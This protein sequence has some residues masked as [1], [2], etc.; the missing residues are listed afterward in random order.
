MFDNMRGWTDPA[1]NARLFANLSN[2]ETSGDGQAYPTATGFGSAGLA[3]STSYIYIAIRRGPMKVPTVGTSV[4]SPIADSGSIGATVTNGFPIDMQ[5]NR[6]YANN[7]NSIVVDRLRGISTDSTASVASLQINTTAAES[8]GTNYSLFWGNTSFQ[9]PNGYGD[10]PVIYW[11]FRRAPSFFDEVCYT[12]NQTVRAISHNLGIAPELFLLFQ[13]SPAADVYARLANPALL[14]S[15]KWLYVNQT[16]AVQTSTNIWNNTAPTA[17][18]FTVGNST[19]SNITGTTYVAYLFATCAGVSK[20]GSYTGNGTTQTI[21]C[22][23]GAGGARFVL[24]KR[25][26][27][28]GDWYVYDTA[29]GMTVL[30]DPYL[31]LNNVAAQVATLGSVTTVSTGFALDSAILAA[32]NVNAGTYIFL[33]IA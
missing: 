15:N 12:G 23:F 3:A 19:A 24:I 8:V 2:A 9:V 11:S 26:D 20:V 21:N 6:D 30:T 31:R 32:I 5:I 18:T 10:V 25:T 17:S 27:A 4:F 14:G 28:V 33:A 7:G 13:R 22:G 16:D 1:N 29:R